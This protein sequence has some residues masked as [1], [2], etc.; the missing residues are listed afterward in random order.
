[1]NYPV[2]N[3]NKCHLLTYSETA[4]DIHTSDATVSNEKIVKL[5]GINL[6]GRLNLD[7]HVA[8]LINKGQ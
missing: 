2:G 4:I 1:M 7:F 6:E 5:L 3:A 8:T